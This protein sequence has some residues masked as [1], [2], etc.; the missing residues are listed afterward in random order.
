MEAITIWHNPRCSKSRQTLQLLEDNGVTPTI[1]HYLDTPPDAA[2]LERVLTELGM[3][4][5]QL[6]RT[7]EP[8]YKELGL[9]D[10]SLSNAQL[11]AAMVTHPK[12]IE[13]PVVRIGTRAALGRP[14]ENILAILP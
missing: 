11:I 13:R 2:E 5:R 1:V 6:L 4:P 8:L 10:P 14:P 3:T 9:A 7:G 12:L